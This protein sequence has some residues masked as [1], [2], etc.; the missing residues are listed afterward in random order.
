MPINIG[1]IDQAVR[2]VDGL[3]LVAYA[4]QDGLMGLG[5][6]DWSGAARDGV[7]QELPASTPLRLFELPS[8]PVRGDPSN[9]IAERSRPA[10]RAS[11]VR[12]WP[13]ADPRR[14]GW[15]TRSRGQPLRPL[16]PPRSFD[17][18][19]PSLQPFIGADVGGVGLFGPEPD[20]CAPPRQ[21]APQFLHYGR[22]W[23]KG[24]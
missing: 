23:S 6:L 10:H 9:V 4:P 2:I 14:L 18:V 13:D 20:N 11:S 5:R 7:L 22:R 15:F 17:S 24:T 19:A 21:A 8:P 3:A 12:P 1:T 16:Q